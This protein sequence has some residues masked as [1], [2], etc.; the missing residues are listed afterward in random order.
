MTASDTSFDRDT[1]AGYLV[2]HMARLFARELEAGLKPLGIGI[3]MFPALLQ[4]WEKDGR[5]QRELVTALDIEQP[6]L[7]N[8]LTRMEKKGL[9]T[10]KPDPED[11]RAQRIHLTDR[12]RALQAEAEARATA[13][14][15][16]ALSGFSES[17]KDRFLK[18]IG[19]V[20]DAMKA[21]T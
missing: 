17:E 7:A 19:R 14:N 13:V 21:P 2:N 15:T 20:I 12:G 16:R 11:G 18:D 5:T 10:R 4:L 9:I 6:T 8:T 1:S 3:G